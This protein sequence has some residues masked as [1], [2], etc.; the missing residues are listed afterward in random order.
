MRWV[1]ANLQGGLL[2]ELAPYNSIGFDPNPSYIGR[3]EAFSGRSPGMES[4]PPWNGELGL[5]LHIIGS[6][7]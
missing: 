3:G 1:I 2:Y 7:G 4:S 5:L 6:S